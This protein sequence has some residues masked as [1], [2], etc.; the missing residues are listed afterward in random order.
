[1][2]LKAISVFDSKAQLHSTPQFV[3]TKADALR[4]WEQACNAP[5]SIYFKHPEDFTLLEIGEYD[6]SSGVM[7]THTTQVPLGR[8]LEF[9]RPE[10]ANVTSIGKAK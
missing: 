5:E 2:K 10:L 7:T 9:K 4:S 1:M 8:A 3:R 6:E